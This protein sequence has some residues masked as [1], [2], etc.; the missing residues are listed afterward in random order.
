MATHS[1]FLVGMIPWTEE[2]GRLQSMWLQ[3]VR[4][5]WETEHAHTH[6][7]IIYIK[8]TVYININYIYGWQESRDLNCINT[9]ISALKKKK[10]LYSYHRICGWLNLQMHNCGYWRMTLNLYTDFQL[11][12][13]VSAL[14]ACIIQGFHIHKI[15]FLYP[16]WNHWT[17]GLFPHLGYCE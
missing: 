16:F 8:N 11:G 13:E 17:L 9:L 14:N 10:I 3:R 15:C 4:H 12:R 5:S 2:P 6:T 7:R 1:N